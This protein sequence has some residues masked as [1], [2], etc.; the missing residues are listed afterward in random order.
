MLEAQA[1]T[2]VNSLPQ[3]TVAVIDY[4]LGNV[5]SV[6]GAIEKVGHVGVLTK[7]KDKILSSD[8]AILPGVGAFGDGMRNLRET[9]LV[10]IIYQY[11]LDMKKPFLGICLGMQ[12]MA[13]RGR[14]FGENI[15]LNLIHGEVVPLNIG[16]G[17]R[18]IHM[19][20][21]DLSV[22]D[23]EPLFIDLEHPVVY[24]VHGYHFILDNQDMEIAYTEYGSKVTAGIKRGNIVGLQF[25]PE[26]SQKD[27]LKIL[28][29]F[30]ESC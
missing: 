30:I 29:N 12:L 17:L 6:L 24:Y 1:S 8:V 18:K 11:A 3:K 19:G 9:G 23:G 25:H 16:G 13:S 5:A 2:E 15:G 20:W 22:K 28:K 21:N 14:E 10:D 26:K 7:E 27:G 4:G